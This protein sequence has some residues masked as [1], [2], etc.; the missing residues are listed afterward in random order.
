[1][2]RISLLASILVVSAGAG[3]APACSD[4]NGGDD[5][6]LGPADSSSSGD[7]PEEVSF[8]T[9]AIETPDHYSDFPASPIVDDSL[10]GTSVSFADGTAAAPCVYEPESDA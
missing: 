3:L 5:T 8:D 10:S 4:A 9:P 7:A 2:R 6:P 1:M